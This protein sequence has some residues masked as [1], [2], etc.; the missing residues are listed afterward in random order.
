MRKILILLLI[1]MSSVLYAQPV[2]SNLQ[3]EKLTSKAISKIRHKFKIG[4]HTKL[5]AILI[6][7]FYDSTMLDEYPPAHTPDIYTIGECLKNIRQWH[8]EIYVYDK[9]L[10][11]VFV[12][13]R[14]FWGSGKYKREY[15]IANEQDR[16]IVSYLAQ[17]QYQKVYNL[18]LCLSHQQTYSPFVF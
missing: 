14:I 10:H 12:Y 17:E 8:Y 11:Y 18:S 6:P 3:S 1:I 16:L 15:Y 7:S 4:N 5:F 9:S 2:F 13:N